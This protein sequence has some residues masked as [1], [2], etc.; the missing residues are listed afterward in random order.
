MACVSSLPRDTR[1]PLGPCPFAEEIA[2]MDV[3]IAEIVIPPGRRA[4]SDTSVN[5][6]KN[7]IEQVGLLQ[8]ILLTPDLRLV[9]GA[10][11]VAACKLLGH[12]TIRAET[13][14]LGDLDRELAEIDENLIRNELTALER[15]EHLARR[16]AIY[17]LLHPETKQGGD[18]K[19]EDAK[20][21]PQDAVLIE[22]FTQ[23]TAK[24]VGASRDT[25]ERSVRIGEDITPEAR[26]AIRATPTADN[27]A[28]LLRL[29]KLPE[30]EQVAVAEEVR[31][32]GKTVK[33]VELERKREAVDEQTRGQNLTALV[34]LANQTDWLPAVCGL[35]GRF[36]P[37]DLLLTDPPY[38]TEIADIG[39]FAA[40][41]LP[42]ALACVKDTGR[43]YVFIGAY[44]LELLSYLAVGLADERMVLEQVLVWTY[45]NTLGPSPTHAYKQNW[46]ACLYFVGPEAPP[47]DCPLMNEQFSVQDVNAPDGRMG[48]RYHAWQ[49][50]DDLAE[51]IVRHSTQ[52]GDLVIDPFCGT[53][54]FVLA[55]ARLGRRGWGCDNDA[56]MVA[57]ACKRGCQDRDVTRERTE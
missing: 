5:A 34:S 17:E 40:D 13:V 39:A 44:P 36:G 28:D 14:D 56:A 9:A 46:Q 20:S 30:D 29:A 10:H 25:V 45:R 15:G 43:A 52:P 57:L 16:K 6:L 18:R 1:T 24:K 48:D 38:S 50:P 7:S 2:I 42:S 41:W 37:A 51:R 47:L 49:K 21:K 11:R 19:S 12:E 22:P 31:D 23:D 32:T 55:A 4:V 35:T 26:D 33:Q 3:R 8:A 27:Q 53:G 54:T